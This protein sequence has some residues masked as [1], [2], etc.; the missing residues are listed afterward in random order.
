MYTNGVNLHVVQAGP[1]D[2]PLVILLHGFPEFWYGWRNQIPALAQA[3]YCVWAPDQRGYNL[4]AKPAGVAAYQLDKLAADVV[5]LLDAAG[6]QQAYLV[7]HDWGAAVTWRIANRYPQR[8][9]KAAVLNVPHPFVLAKYLRRSWRQMLRSTYIAFFQLPGL[10][11]RLMAI[12]NW[13]PL[14]DAMRRTAPPGL[15]P[16]AEMQRYRAAWSQPGA[17]MAMLNWYRAI[18]QQPPSWSPSPRI[19][20]PLLMI[21][22]TA[23]SALERTLAPLSMELCD[24]GRLHLI[25]GA[26]H[27]VQHEAPEQVNQ[28][29]LEHLAA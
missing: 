20:P 25:E 7:G 18:V 14:V 12:R 6:R 8:I 21:W 10:P 28:L 19:K 2:G 24:Q 26:S 27:W 1:A 11:E 5:G 16:D 3:G 29:L 13:Q 22:G 23:D 4:S 15:F 9:A 17:M